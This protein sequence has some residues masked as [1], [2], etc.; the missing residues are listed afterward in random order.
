MDAND[1]QAIK[2]N[3]KASGGS[4]VNVYVTAELEA[5]ANGGSDIYYRGNPAKISKNSSG[6]SD[7]TKKD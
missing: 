6:G 3:A 2:V 7:I 5:S 4:D 1:L